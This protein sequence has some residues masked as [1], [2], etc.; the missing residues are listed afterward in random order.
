MHQ[1]TLKTAGLTALRAGA[2]ANKRRAMRTA[3]QITEN[4]SSMHGGEHRVDEIPPDRGVI[5]AKL[6]GGKGIT[7]QTRIEL[8]QT[9]VQDKSVAAAVVMKGGHLWL[10]TYN[11]PYKIHL[12]TDAVGVKRAF[13]SSIFLDQPRIW[14]IAPGAIELIARVVHHDLIDRQAWVGIMNQKYKD[15][16]VSFIRMGTRVKEKDMRDIA[17]DVYVSDTGPVPLERLR[18]A[19]SADEPYTKVHRV[20]GQIRWPVV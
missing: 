17:E 18:S 7:A 8:A 19:M 6:T 1:V 15:P 9:C 5:V 12:Y 2:E 3:E 16:N 11:C 20:P 14:S 4:R 13:E 10:V